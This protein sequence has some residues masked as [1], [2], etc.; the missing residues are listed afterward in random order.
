MKK[1]Y[2][3]SWFLIADFAGAFLAWLI[4]F[5]YR[6]VILKEEIETLLKL[7]VFASAT[8]I[9]FFWLFLYWISG[10]YNEIYRKSRIKD[11]FLLFGINFLGVVLVFFALLLDDEGVTKYTEYYKTFALYY[12][13]HTILSVSS[14]FIVIT[15]IKKQ[16]KK[17]KIF[18]NTIIV[19]SGKNAFDIY[20]QLKGNHELL[21]LRFLGFVTVGDETGNEFGRNLRQFGSYENLPTLIRR[22][23]VDQ[24]IIA[25]E[26]S[27]YSKIQ[28][29]LN[30][31]QFANIK[32]GIIPDIYQLLLGSVKVTQLLG[33]PLI[34]INQHLIPLWQKIVKRLID[35]VASASVLFFGFPF[36]IF[37]AIMTRVTSK[38]PVL[39][40]QER[41]GKDGKPFQIVKFRSMH[42]NAETDG[43]AL[44]SSIDNRITSWGKFI[45]KYRLDE[46]PQFYNVLVGEMSLVG[47]RPERQFFID[48]IIKVAP[49]YQHLQKVR[50]GLTSFGQVKFGYA[51]N[52]EEMVRRLKYDIFYIENM[53]LAMDFRILFYTVI[54]I[55]QARGK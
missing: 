12:I 42:T 55:I 3:L 38:G 48:Q 13:V 41:V 29:I 37:L 44:A 27:E 50:P 51:E 11:A 23:F 40:F 33:V 35:I 6:K 4:F 18:F 16:I 15:E 54:I 1:T 49:E 52:V 36:F 32:V 28:P 17:R 5:Y 34:E 14:R 43:P 19:G 30:K 8:T 2:H 10:L 7:Y 24:I 26:T 53:S 45:R 20:E 31:T 25:L 39:Y 21:G 46:L 9:A 22:C 47:P